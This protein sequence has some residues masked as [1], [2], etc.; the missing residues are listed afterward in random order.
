MNQRGLGMVCGSHGRTQ[1]I[2]WTTQQKGKVVGPTSPVVEVSMRFVTATQYSFGS[3]TPQTAVKKCGCRC[4]V[5]VAVTGGPE[6]VS[7][8]RY[9]GS[10]NTYW[11]QVP[12]IFLGG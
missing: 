12:A 8:C 9:S 3:V 2:Q 6:I 5:I 4:V 10:A 11:S 7:A 1:R